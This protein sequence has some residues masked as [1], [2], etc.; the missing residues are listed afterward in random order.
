[1]YII[2]RQGASRMIRMQFDGQ[3]REEAL[4]ECSSA[5]KKLMEY[6]P[7]TALEEAPLP[8]NQT[9]T[10]IAAPVIQVTVNQI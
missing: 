8:P 2:L 5:L 10:E 1:M 9:H 6:L 3:T 4:K 7:V